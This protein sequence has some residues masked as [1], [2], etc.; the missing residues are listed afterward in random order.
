MAIPDTAEGGR[1]G[2][3]TIGGGEADVVGVLVMAGCQLE[4]QLDSRR[5]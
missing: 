3:M 4:L 1:W 5:W 2:R